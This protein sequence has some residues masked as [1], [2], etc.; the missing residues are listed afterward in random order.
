MV[1][2]MRHGGSKWVIMECSGR[3]WMV[4]QR[5]EKRKKIN[6]V[7][8]LPEHGHDTGNPTTDSL[9]SHDALATTYPL[10]SKELPTGSITTLDLVVIITWNLVKHQYLLNSSIMRGTSYTTLPLNKYLDHVLHTELIPMT[11]TL[12]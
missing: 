8:H 1:W 2:S 5:K 7:R 10:M 11:Q 4:V 6:E 3:F 12:A 9:L